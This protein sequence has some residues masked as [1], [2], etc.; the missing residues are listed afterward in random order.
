MDEKLEIKLYIFLYPVKATKPSTIRQIG[1]AFVIIGF[2]VVIVAFMGC[3]G[4]AKV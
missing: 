2:I 3:C 1:Y 4:A